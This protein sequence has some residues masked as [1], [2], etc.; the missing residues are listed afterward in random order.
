MCIYGGY[1]H[2]DQKK[3]GELVRGANSTLAILACIVR[4]AVAL[5]SPSRKAIGRGRG[6]RCPEQPAAGEGVEV[7]PTPRHEAPPSAAPPSLHCAE[8][9]RWRAGD[10]HGREDALA[11]LPAGPG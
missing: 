1:L 9:G 5:P 10:G 4:G 8:G 6:P 7:G 11:D 2:R 3:V